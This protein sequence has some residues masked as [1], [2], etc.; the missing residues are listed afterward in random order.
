MVSENTID[1]F[2]DEL[3]RQK[4][5]LGG[6]SAAALIG[7]IAAALVSMVGNLT[8]AKAQSIRGRT[9]VCSHTSR[10]AATRLAKMIEEDVEAFAVAYSMPRQTKDRRSKQH[11]TKPPCLPMRCCRASRKVITIAKLVA[12]KPIL[13]S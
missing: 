2:L 5:T 13:L 8:I 11:L 3:A 10:R 9:Q 6:G 7:A 1:A 12:E 4:G